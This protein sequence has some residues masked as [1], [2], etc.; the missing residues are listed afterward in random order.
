MA[1]PPAPLVKHSGRHGC[2]A[3]DT[4][5]ILADSIGKG[6]VLLGAQ[7]VELSSWLQATN[8]NPLSRARD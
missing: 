5:P 8:T 3:C 7:I 6:L 2:A 1:A 4:P